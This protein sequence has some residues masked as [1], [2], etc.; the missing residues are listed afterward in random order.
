MP[1]P[2][3]DRAAL[4]GALLLLAATP[5]AADD[6][7]PPPEDCPRGSVGT[8][9]H[10]GEWC[11]ATTC[12]T[13]GDCTLQGLRAQGLDHVGALA[14][15]VCREAPLC[16]IEEEYQLGGLWPDEPPTR[17]RRIARGA[18]VDGRCP[19]G[20]DC[21][22]TRRCVP[23]EGP[24]ATPAADQPSTAA[25]PREA[26]DEGGCA[27][28][29]PGASGPWAALALVALVTAAARRRRRPRRRACAR[30]APAR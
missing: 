21:G 29:S 9:E 24:R 27:V 14:P 7:G 26:A 5:A 17:T 30:R 15:M 3:P 12:T 1:V 20:G 22:A 19:A 25:D 6:I 8:S 2:L 16:V 4:L 13:D 23:R 11:A 28:G 18:C 10:A